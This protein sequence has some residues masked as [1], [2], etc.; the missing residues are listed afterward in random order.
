MKINNPWQ[1]YLALREKNP[2]IFKNLEHM[3]IVLDEES[4]REYERDHDVSIGV[5]YESDYSYL[6][7]DLLKTPNG[8]I[9]YERV[10]PKNSNAVVIVPMYED[11]FL[12]LRQAR[13]ALRQCQYGFPRGYGE[14]GILAEDNACKEL[15][16]EIGVKPTSLKRL[17]QVVADSGLSGNK[18]DI[19]LANIDAYNLKKSYEGIE[20][21]VLLTRD[22]LEKWIVSGKIN[23]GFSLSAM[24][25]LYTSEDKGIE[26]ENGKI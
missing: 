17:G 23:D 22:E 25:L 24:A 18:V 20:E 3:E 9:A 16:E 21:V 7:V 15:Y 10:V 26:E 19:F 1:S 5:I 11:K 14:P 8:L 13:H 4:V 6:L 2:D 12:I